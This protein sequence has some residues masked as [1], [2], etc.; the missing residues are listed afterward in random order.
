MAWLSVA[1][2]KLHLGKTATVDDE[3]LY[4]FIEA[5]ESLVDRL[6]GRVRPPLDPEVEY[7]DG[8]C[9][10]IVLRKSPVAAIVEVAQLGAVLAQADLDVPTSAGWHASDLDMAAGIIRH[11]SWFSWGRNR[12]RVT[13][14]PGLLVIPGDVRIATLDIVQQL[15]QASQNG[16]AGAFPARLDAGVPIGFA[17]PAR[18]RELLGLPES[19][20][21]A[22]TLVG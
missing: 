20:A 14:H 16:V 8:G 19:G 17:I 10:V 22:E 18:A 1:E 4:G 3:E 11:T 15:W 7:H 6:I 21:P 2:A 5:A 9:D 12:V 13:Y